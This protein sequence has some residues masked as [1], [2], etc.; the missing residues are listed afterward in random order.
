MN[1]KS[2]N[3]DVRNES[4]C[5]SMLAHGCLDLQL[6][7]LKLKFGVFDVYLLEK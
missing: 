3:L 7:V 6:D 2:L 1:L 5:G 4:S